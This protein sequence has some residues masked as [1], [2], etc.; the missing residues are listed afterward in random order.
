MTRVQKKKN[1][2]YVVTIPKELAEGMGLDQGD[3]ADWSIISRNAMRADF[4]SDE[5]VTEE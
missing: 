3:E 1:G 5:E 2:Q 4:S